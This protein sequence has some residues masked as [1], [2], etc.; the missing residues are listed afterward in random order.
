MSFINANFT[1]GFFVPSLA[2]ISPVHMCLWR[3]QRCKN[4]MTIMTTKG[5]GLITLNII[6]QC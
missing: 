1:E 2:E 5:N 3:R 6:D 4:S